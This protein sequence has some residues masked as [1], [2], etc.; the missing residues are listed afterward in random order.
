M[1]PWLWL[2]QQS[3]GWCLLQWLHGFSLTP[4]I[5]SIYLFQPG[6]ILLSYWPNAASLLT[7]GIHS[8]QRGIPHH[9]LAIDKKDRRVQSRD[10]FGVGGSSGLAQLTVKKFLFVKHK[11]TLV[12]IIKFIIVSQNFL[13]DVHCISAKWLFLK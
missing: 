7:N 4:P 11:H 10:R 12:F 3:S 13:S 9:S 2:T 5:L 1:S 8:I 6:C